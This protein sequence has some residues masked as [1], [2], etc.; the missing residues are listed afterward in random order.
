MP[1]FPRNLQLFYIKLPTRLCEKCRE[2][3][4]QFFQLIHFLLKET[5][6]LINLT[7]FLRR[8]QKNLNF[9]KIFCQR[10]LPF[11][12]TLVMTRKI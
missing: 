11:S 2:K 3:Y 5:N 6:F 7:I 1:I 10:E 9:A 12:T 4:L 8:E